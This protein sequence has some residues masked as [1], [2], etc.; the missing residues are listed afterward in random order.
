MEIID[1]DSKVLNYCYMISNGQ[2]SNKI[3]ILSFKTKACAQVSTLE[4][5]SFYTIWK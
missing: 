1:N 3:A 4:D 2:Y 5:G